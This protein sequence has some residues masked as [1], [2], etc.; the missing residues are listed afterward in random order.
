MPC[1]AHALCVRLLE[2][3]VLRN[4]ALLGV[5][6]SPSH[7]CNS[8]RAAVT[9]ASGRQLRQRRGHS[10]Q[11]FRSLCFGAPCALW[12]RFARRVLARLSAG[13]GSVHARGRAADLVYVPVL[14]A[15]IGSRLHVTF[16][17]RPTSCNALLHLIR[18]RFQNT[19]WPPF[20]EHVLVPILGTWLRLL[21]IYICIWS[22]A[23]RAGRVAER[24]AGTHFGS[25]F[26]GGFLASRC[27]FACVCACVRVRAVG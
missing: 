4:I 24:A 15:E 22:S 3:E 27:F 16:R 20:W 6:S 10:L 23:A 26:R 14:G 1:Y 9:F 25:R 12:L 7:T 18:R 8:S 19:F 2:C 5:W 11:V 17:V 21:C 13:T